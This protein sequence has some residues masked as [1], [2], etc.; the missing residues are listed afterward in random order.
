MQEFNSLQSG[1]ADMTVKWLKEQ[2]C[3]LCQNVEAFEA[4]CQLL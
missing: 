4:T 2:D 3:L 1:L